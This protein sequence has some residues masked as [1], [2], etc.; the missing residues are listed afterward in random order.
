MEKDRNSPREGSDHILL[1][2]PQRGRYNILSIQLAK[3]KLCC[4]F[5]LY[6]IYFH[7]SNSKEMLKLINLELK[8]MPSNIVVEENYCWWIRYCTNIAWEGIQKKVSIMTITYLWRKMGT[9]PWKFKEIHS[10]LTVCT[11]LILALNRYKSLFFFQIV[12]LWV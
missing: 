3:R 5:W 7:A 2:A 6:I 1:V 4:A 12:G 11:L 10:H 8:I 9:T